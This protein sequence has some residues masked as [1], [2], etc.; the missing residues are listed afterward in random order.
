MPIEAEPRI[1]RNMYQ[2]GCNLIGYFDDLEKE[3]AVK[4]RGSVLVFL[5]GM[6][7]IQALHAILN[8]S[9]IPK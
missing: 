6:P 4:E 5:P 9:T 8:K 3:D 2:L 7:E 1:D